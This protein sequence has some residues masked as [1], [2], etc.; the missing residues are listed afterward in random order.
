MS[1]AIQAQAPQEAASAAGKF[2]SPLLEVRGIDTFYGSSQILFGLDIAVPRRHCVALL[3]RNGAGKSTTMKSIMRL[4]PPRQGSVHVSGRDVSRLRPDQIA[5]AGLGY[6]PEDRQ[7]FKLQTV[8]GNLRLGA[9]KGPAGQ[10]EWPLERIYEFFPLLR[11]ARRKSAGLLSGGQQQM[12]SIGRALAGN[13]EL[14]LLDE[15][16]EGLAP[17]I[18]DQIQAL[19][20][21]LRNEGVTLLV[22][23]Q[24]MRFC[25]DIASHVAVIDHGTIVFSG[26]L[27]DFRGNPEIASRY[28]AV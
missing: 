2:G 16:S 12:L 10:D 25:M 24:N 27:D 9:K 19:V 3:G 23:E 4:A 21:Q 11:D 28:L 20:L 8:E 7:I 15:P 1:A 13:P 17:V 18:M 22:A 5:N 14:L 6:V 26:T